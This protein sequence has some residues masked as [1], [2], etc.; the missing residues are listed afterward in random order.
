MHIFL[1]HLN[2]FTFFFFSLD[3]EIKNLVLHRNGK[4]IVVIKISTTSHICTHPKKAVFVKEI[5]TFTVLILNVICDSSELQVMT[6]ELWQNGEEV[7]SF[8][9]VLDLQFS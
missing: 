7:L 8:G 2:C 6:A 9:E 4:G 3:P 5:F 1:Y